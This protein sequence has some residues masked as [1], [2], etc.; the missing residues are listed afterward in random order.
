MRLTLLGYF[1][2]MTTSD[3]LL[4]HACRDAKVAFLDSWD[5][6]L[7]DETMLHVR[8]SECD[9]VVG[10]E[11]M[12]TR[13][14]V[15]KESGATGLTVFEQWFKAGHGPAL[16]RHDVEEVLRVLQGEAL[17]HVGSE[18]AT[19]GPGESVIVP[20]GTAHRFVN[21]GED[22]L[23]IQGIVAAPVLEGYFIE[24]GTFWAWSSES[25]R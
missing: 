6:D 18:A 19:V 15:W 17:F 5:W 8:D 9:I 24:P 2:R 13:M 16:H 21:S 3:K 22:D 1:Y 14:Y 12:R 25:N 7:E 4:G 23:H 10:R 20:P 11:G